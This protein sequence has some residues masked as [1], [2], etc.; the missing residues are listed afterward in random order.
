MT[1]VSPR[2]EPNKRETLKRL[3][4]VSRREFAA[5]GLS[6]ARIDD[7]AQ[8][9]GVTKQL[10]YHYFGSKEALFTHVLDDSS[11]NIMSELLSI[12][13][14]SMAPP[15]AI[16]AFLDHVADQYKN[17]AFLGA[18]AQ[19]GIRYHENH[20]TPDNK[21]IGMAP[22]LVR[23][24]DAVLQRGAES[25][26][27]ISGVDPH[28]FLATASLLVSGAFTSRYAVSTLVGYCTASGEGMKTWHNHAVEF[29]MSAISTRRP[30]HTQHTQRT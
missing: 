17:N 2:P 29:I 19:E 6:G 27:F 28:L 24:L 22:A 18:L 3:L 15:D 14:E 21:F 13:L 20:H 7:I 11:F 23:K 4:N 10:V 30:H 5:K 9:A 25:G 26:H 1:A 8:Q 16:R 12:E